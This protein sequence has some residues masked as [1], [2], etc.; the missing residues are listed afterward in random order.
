MLLAVALIV[1]HLCLQVL[2]LHPE[3]RDPAQLS[4]HVLYS[5]GP[6]PQWTMDVMLLPEYTFAKQDADVSAVN[7]RS[8]LTVA[9]GLSDNAVELHS[10]LERATD[11]RAHVCPVSILCIQS[12]TKHLT[13]TLQ[14]S[15]IVVTS[16][17]PPLASYYLLDN[18]YVCILV[19]P[20]KPAA[21]ARAPDA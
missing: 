1:M 4:M 7:P 12:P 15:M 14:R 18:G 10:V 13:A 11:Q 17:L 9:I 3:A 20:A 5:G 21:Q 2:Q 8:K 16:V 19:C 6:F